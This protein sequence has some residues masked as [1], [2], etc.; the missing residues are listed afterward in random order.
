MRAAKIQPED[1]RDRNQREKGRPT[2]ASTSSFHT[3]SL[4]SPR[5]RRT[6][7]SRHTCGLYPEGG[8]KRPPLGVPENALHRTGYCAG[9]STIRQTCTWTSRSTCTGT[10]TL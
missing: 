7:F 10:H 5:R 1:E 4:R 9:C 3:D 8:K 6:H 2:E